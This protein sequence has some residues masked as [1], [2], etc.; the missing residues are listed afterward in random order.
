MS[1][2]RRVALTMVGPARVIVVIAYGVLRL[3]AWPGMLHGAV[4][5]N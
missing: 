2:A 1:L 4:S 5:T 3:Y